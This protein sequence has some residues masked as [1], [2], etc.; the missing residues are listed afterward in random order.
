M[1]TCYQC[2]PAVQ[3][4]ERATLPSGRT[5]TYCT[6]CASA[7]M[8][9]LIRANATLNPIEPACVPPSA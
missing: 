3:A 5:L 9:G 2:G 8:V 4:K 6:H 7:N 1:E